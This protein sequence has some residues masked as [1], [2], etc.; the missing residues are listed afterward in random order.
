MIC[1]SRRWRV[2]SPNS[3]RHRVTSSSRAR[4]AGDSATDLQTPSRCHLMLHHREC[5]SAFSRRR[6]GS[7]RSGKRRFALV[8]GNSRAVQ[9]RS[10]DFQAAVPFRSTIFSSIRVIREIRS[11]FLSFLA[12]S[13]PPARLS[14]CV[15]LHGGWRP[16]ISFRRRS[17]KILRRRAAPV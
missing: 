10:A 8:C 16:N 17:G 2:D 6:L 1:R 15:P 7:R 12:E 9:R 14:Q 3:F 4:I 13:S 11:S 5:G